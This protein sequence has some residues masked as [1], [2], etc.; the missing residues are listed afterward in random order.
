MGA[1]V[2]CCWIISRQLYL[3]NVGDSRIYL[4]RGRYIYQLSNDHTWIQEA[5]D[6][7]L[8]T[9]EQARAHPNAH[10]IRRYLG[11]K[12]PVVPDTRL[13]LSPGESDAQAEANQGFVLLPGDRLLLC[14]DGLTDLVSNDEIRY[15]LEG[16]PLEPALQALINLANGRG[17]HDNITLVALQVPR[18]PTAPNL[19]R[20]LPAAQVIPQKAAPRLP[21]LVAGLALLAI[22]A[23]CLLVVYLV[24]QVIEPAASGWLSLLSG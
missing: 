12:Q 14:S 13:R 23:L 1:T 2:A 22:L 7:G 24:S 9:P 21:I 18:E 4:L 16:A 3:A 11:S 17:G 15:H 10:V 20:T 6:H 19:M 5:M 8:L